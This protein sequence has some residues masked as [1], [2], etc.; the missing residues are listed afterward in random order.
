MKKE[1]YMQTLLNYIEK[2]ETRGGG[3]EKDEKTFIQLKIKWFKWNKN[4]HDYD[5]L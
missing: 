2:Q 4:H 3:W 1:K 5:P